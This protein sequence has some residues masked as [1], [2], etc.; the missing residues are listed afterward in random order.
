[1]LLDK[2]RLIYNNNDESKDKDSDTMIMDTGVGVLSTVTTRA[3]QVAER[4]NLTTQLIGYQDKANPRMY[5]V[6]NAIIKV[7]LP[8]VVIGG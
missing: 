4:T 6:V 3:W 8:N 2:P 1:M 7:S 5:P